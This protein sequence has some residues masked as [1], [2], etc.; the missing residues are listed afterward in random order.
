[1]MKQGAASDSFFNKT[2]PKDV[3]LKI[4]IKDSFLSIEQGSFDGDT[5]KAQEAIQAF[6]DLH[7]V[8]QKSGGHGYGTLT[9]DGTPHSITPYGIDISMMLAFCKIDASTL[10]VTVP[11][12]NI[13]YLM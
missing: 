1:M 7:E 6:V 11:Y 2:N 10:G 8:T 12:F 3:I 9:V 13:E 4:K 5:D